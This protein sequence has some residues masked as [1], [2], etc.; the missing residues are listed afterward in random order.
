MSFLEGI[1]LSE[2]GKLAMTRDLELRRKDPRAA[3]RFYRYSYQGG[4]DLCLQH[5]EFWWGQVRPEKFMPLSGQLGQCYGTALDAC[6]AD[7]SLVYVE[8]YC[9][10]GASFAISHGWCVDTATNTVV[11]LVLP[12][13]EEDIAKGYKLGRTG[14][15]FVH[16]TRWAYYG[17][18][19]TT[20]L[21]DAH[22]HALGLPM[23]D[24][25]RR[26]AL[27]SPGDRYVEPHDFPILQVP[28]QPNRQEMPPWHKPET[29]TPQWEDEEW[30][31]EDDL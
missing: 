27:E 1:D 12:C 24:R 22:W 26:E 19:F 2:A 16:P 14:M 23:L 11:D 13:S 18:R 3:D 9:T 17:V 5:G 4:A 30:E 25:S 28:Y 15:P 31:E 21:V 29:Q 8:G 10:A 7:D 20:E 6:K